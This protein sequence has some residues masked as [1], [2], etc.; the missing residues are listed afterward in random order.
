MSSYRC[1][2]CHAI[3]K[4]IPISYWAWGYG[5]TKRS[6]AGAIIGTVIPFLGTAMGAVVGIAITIAKYSGKFA[7]EHCSRE[8]RPHPHVA[9]DEK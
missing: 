1:P 9:E 8:F 5:L 7:C 3:T 2:N 4:P 6:L